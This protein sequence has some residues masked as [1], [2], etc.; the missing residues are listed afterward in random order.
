[1]NIIVEGAMPILNIWFWGTMSREHVRHAPAK[2]WRNLCH[3]VGLSAKEMAVPP[4]SPLPVLHV[5]DVRRQ[6]APVADKCL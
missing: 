4:S 3:R 5:A 6:A 2:K 1:M